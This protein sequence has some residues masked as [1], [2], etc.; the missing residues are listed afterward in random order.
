M[1]MPY[2]FPANGGTSRFGA[3]GYPTPQGN[4]EANYDAS[5][6]AQAA[7]AAQPRVVGI[8]DETRVIAGQAAKEVFNQTKDRDVAREVHRGILNQAKQG[9]ALNPRAVLEDLGLVQFDAAS[10]DD[11]NRASALTAEEYAKARSSLANPTPIP[12]HV[13]VET[14]GGVAK[15]PIYEGMDDA[16]AGLLMGRKATDGGGLEADIRPHDTYSQLETQMKYDPYKGENAPQTWAQQLEDRATGRDRGKW[17]A[18]SDA[19][20]NLYHGIGGGNNGSEVD[21]IDANILLQEIKAK[22]GN[23]DS[24]QFL[25][26]LGTWRRLVAT[27]QPGELLTAI[28]SIPIGGGAA[29]AAKLGARAGQVG[30]GVDLGVNTADLIAGMGSAMPSSEDLNPLNATLG[31]IGAGALGRQFAQSVPTGQRTA[32]DVAATNFA[33]N[34]GPTDDP[35]MADKLSRAGDAQVYGDVGAP[36]AIPDRAQSIVT[37]LNRN[38]RYRDLFDQADIRDRD[39]AYSELFDQASR[40]EQGRDYER[41]FDRADIR[42]RARDITQNLR[43]KARYGGVWDELDA[44]AIREADRADALART[45]GEPDLAAMSGIRERVRG[46]ATQAPKGELN[47]KDFEL[48]L[49]YILDITDDPAIHTLARTTWGAVKRAKTKKQKQMLEDQFWD[50]AEK[51]LGGASSKKVMGE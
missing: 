43:A 8:D 6:V 10:K 42:D 46:E 12:G 30:R 48:G 31:L 2:S 29:A 51:L 28:A 25:Q 34:Y 24:E 35:V 39:Q 3:R 45:S 22:Y 36:Q 20:S 33:R 19:M 14:E 40:Q 21:K 16:L 27:V 5:A 1:E 32:E 11:P 18:F 49:R 17:G 7:V 44:A 23:E 37:N 41:L 4:T 13:L 15:Y 47:T 50:R 9:L 38:G 26:D